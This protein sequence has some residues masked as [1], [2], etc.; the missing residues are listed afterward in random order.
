MALQTRW[1][2]E[3]KQ[4]ALS[5]LSNTQGNVLAAVEAADGWIST[6][7]VVKALLDDDE[8]YDSTNAKAANARKA[9][10]RLEALGLIATQR[11]GNYRSYRAVEPAEEREVDE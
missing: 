7:D 11:A 8:E 2:Q 4:R 6:R 9:L 10:K 5:N 1:E 3:R